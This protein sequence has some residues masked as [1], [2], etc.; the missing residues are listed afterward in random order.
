MAKAPTRYP[1][2][3]TALLLTGGLLAAI[4]PAPIAQS[5]PDFSRDWP[6][7]GGGPQQ[8][9]YSSLDEIDRSNVRR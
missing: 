8:I 9:R 2:A 6:A 1:F 7:Y 3:A 5:A 4:A